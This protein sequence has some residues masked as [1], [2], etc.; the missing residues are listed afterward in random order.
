M[1]LSDIMGKADL[2]GY[3]IIGLILFTFVFVVLAMRLL[4]QHRSGELDGHDQMPLE[5][6]QSVSSKRTGDNHE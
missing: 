3:A 4:R 1:R 5:D 6:G 2:S